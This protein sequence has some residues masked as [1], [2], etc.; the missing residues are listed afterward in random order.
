MAGAAE[1][2]AWWPKRSWVAGS[3]GRG[4]G[5]RRSGS[6]VHRRAVALPP[7]AAKIPRQAGR[8]QV[9][10]ATGA[11]ATVPRV[12]TATACGSAAP[13]AADRPDLSLEVWPDALTLRIR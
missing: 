13:A 11:R 8:R 1:A 5:E 6:P 4:F 12:I 9:T 10:G 2:D 7:A 3:L